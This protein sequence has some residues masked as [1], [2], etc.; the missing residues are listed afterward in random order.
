MDIKTLAAW[1]N[2]QAK[3]DKRDD[4]SKF[5]K[6]VCANEVDEERCR[7]LAFAAHGDG[8]MLPDDWRY[9]FIVEALS[10]LSETDDP[11]EIELEADVYT[12]DLTR[13][14]NSR[15]SRLGYCDEAVREGLVSE[16]ADMSARLTG[17]QYMEKRE[18]LALVREY[19]EDEASTITEDEEANGAEE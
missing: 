6:F 12:S 10:A 18:V 1:Y 4:G 16:S 8:D 14:L 2:K 9:E 15:N 13:W 7:A 5:Y 17:G 11:D 3:Q 19:L